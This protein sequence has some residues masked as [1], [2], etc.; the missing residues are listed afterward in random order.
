MG[1]EVMG[2]RTQ[3]ALDSSSNALAIWMIRWDAF[4]SGPF[5]R[6]ESVETRI[7]FK[8]EKFLSKLAKLQKVSDAVKQAVFT[9]R[10]LVGPRTSKP[11]EDI[12][13]SDVAWIMVSPVAR[14]PGS[15]K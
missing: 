1:R 3:P 13:K 8:R 15:L 12:M 11:R 14:V 5:S 9:K 10:K 7:P 6:R 4:L 2:G